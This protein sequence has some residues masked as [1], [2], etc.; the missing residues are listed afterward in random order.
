[1]ILGILGGMFRTS[2]IHLSRYPFKTYIFGYWRDPCLFE[3]PSLNNVLHMHKNNIKLAGFATSSPSWVWNLMSI[4]SHLWIIAFT[5]HGCSPRIRVVLDIFVASLDTHMLNVA[6]F[7]ANWFLLF[8][9]PNTLKPNLHI[10]SNFFIC[11]L[12]V[13]APQIIWPN[14]SQNLVIK[15]FQTPPSTSPHLQHSIKFEQCFLQ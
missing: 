9:K 6:C 8:I 3:P 5:F 12:L 15:P 11:L 13:L 2:L 14:Y 7:V 1:M 10:F 4:N